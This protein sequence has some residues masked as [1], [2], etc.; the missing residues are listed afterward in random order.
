VDAGS[1]LVAVLAGV[2]GAILGLGAD[3]FAVRWPEHDPEDAEHPADRPLGWRTAVVVVTS[4]VAFA[5]LP[6][7]FAGDPLASLAFGAWFATLVVGLATDLDQRLL[8]DV[9]TLPVIPVALV[10]AISGL[11]PL[12]G[13][14]WVG[15]VIAA[16]AIPA[17]LYLPSIPFGAGAFG[18]GDVKMLAGFG[19]LVGLAR[20][21]GGVLFG[22]LF[23]G[24]VLLVLLAARRITRRTYVPFGPFLII[25]A[26]WAVLVLQPA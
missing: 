20:A 8:P 26:M 18:M 12:V 17:V 1:P 14:G 19:L 23:A 22:L 10:Y 16:I 25:G 15:A 13:D 7:R 9:L 5:L 21:L 2:L 4:A 24:A 3:R 11:N 6:A